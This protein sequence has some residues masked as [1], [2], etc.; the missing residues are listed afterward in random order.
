[1]KEEEFERVKEQIK[2]KF[3]ENERVIGDLKT[4]LKAEKDVRY[5]E[6]MKFA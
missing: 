6:Q 2:I 5:S 3:V 4:Q 1:M